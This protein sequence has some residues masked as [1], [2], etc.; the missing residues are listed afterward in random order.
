MLNNK[1]SHE[2]VKVK[3]N[4]NNYFEIDPN[5]KQDLYKSNSIIKEFF[6][7]THLQ[8]IIVNKNQNLDNKC[9][10]EK[11]ILPAFVNMGANNSKIIESKNNNNTVEFDQ[12]SFK[13]LTKNLNYKIK[14][15]TKEELIKIELENNGKLPWP[16]N[17][18]FLSA[19][20]TKSTIDSQVIRLCSLNP[21]GQCSVYIQFNFERLKP[22]I[23]TCC[24]VFSA[25]GKIFGDN[26]QI[27]IEIY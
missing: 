6:E 12:Y 7:K 11:E 9:L 26:I 2:E 15:G 3:N 18:T 19:E 20:E 22:D 10:K 21:E 8:T 27:N 4:S 13:C 14:E 24:L 17:Q 1:N 23:Y 16:E 25:K 5:S